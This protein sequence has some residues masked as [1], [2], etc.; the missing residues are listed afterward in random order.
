[1]FKRTTALILSLVMLTCVCT[2]CKDSG[3]ASAEIKLPIYGGTDITYEV[4]TAQYMDISETESMGA[5]IGYPYA[6]ILSY[7]A[8]AQ[9]T[10]F[11]AVKGRS[12]TEGEILA[13]LDSSDLDYEINNQQTIVDTAYASSLSGG[14][15]ARLQYEIEKYTLD[16]LLAEKESY[17]IRAPYDGTITYVNRGTPGDQVARGDVCCMVSPKE[18]VQ[19]YIDGGNASKF[20][21]GQEVIVKIDGDSYPATVV[22]AP[23]TLPATASGNAAR[24][25]VFALEEGVMDTLL[26]EN[27]MAIAAGWATVCVTTEKKNVLAVP[28]AAVKTVGSTSSVTLLDGEERYRLSVTVGKSLGGYTEILNGISEGD[29][30]IADGSGTFVSA[31]SSNEDEEFG[32]WGGEWNGNR[33]GEWNGERGERND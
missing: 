19:I 32:D 11:N 14:E 5:T 3:D 16:M 4:A 21:F 26:Q 28:D 17:I 20:R 30:V 6:D 15:S 7:P 27:E 31:S 2:G 18:N 25:A 1:M 33:D 22:M 12:V 24:R 13:E 23:D 29:V 10:A 8:E 9:L